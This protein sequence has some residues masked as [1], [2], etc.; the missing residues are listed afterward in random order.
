MSTAKKE[1]FD[2][3]HYKVEVIQISSTT[4]KTDISDIVNKEY[5]AHVE[6][7]L[8]TNCDKIVHVEKVIKTLIDRIKSIEKDIA[9][10][11]LE[12]KFSKHYEQ[13]RRRQ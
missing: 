7:N 1:N 12:G 6:N 2:I 4:D 8:K 3:D 11:D 5:V 9:L 10:K 13:S